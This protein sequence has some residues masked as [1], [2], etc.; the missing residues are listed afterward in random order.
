MNK[1]FL[2]LSVT[3]MFVL[4]SCVSDQQIMVTQY[5]D[6]EK[7]SSQQELALRVRT[8]V[9]IVSILNVASVQGDPHDTRPI[10]HGCTLEQGEHAHMQTAEVP[11]VVGPKECD[12]D[13]TE[14][15]EEHSEDHA[16]I[17]DR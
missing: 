15:V 9:R 7:E 3:G 12:G 5:D 8:Q 4:S 17:G 6:E 13:D 10:V 1:K 14:E 2:I 16:N 11:D